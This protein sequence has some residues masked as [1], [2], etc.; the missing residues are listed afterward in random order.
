MNPLVSM[1]YVASFGN[2]EPKTARFGRLAQ[3]RSY[4]IQDGYPA[5]RR[6]LVGDAKF[7]TVKN[8]E[9]KLEWLKESRK[10]SQD[11]NATEEE[12]SICVPRVCM[13]IDYNPV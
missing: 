2:K 1:A 4:S 6:S 11:L 3:F 13:T 12:V 10:S 9:A 5:R 7:E 8:R